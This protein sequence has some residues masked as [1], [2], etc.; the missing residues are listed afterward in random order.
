M[1]CQSIDALLPSNRLTA[2]RK[3]AQSSPADFLSR[4][5]VTV[6][7]LELRGIQRTLRSFTTPHPAGGI[8]VDSPEDSANCAA[9]RVTLSCPLRSERGDIRR[10]DLCIQLVAWAGRTSRGQ[11]SSWLIPREQFVG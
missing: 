2:I 6:L 8:S 10:Y 1:R 5:L 3:S 7:Q 9:P 4:I 11:L